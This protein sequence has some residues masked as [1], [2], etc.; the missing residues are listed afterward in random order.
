MGLFNIEGE[1]IQ[2]LSA[3]DLT[4]LLKKL[5]YMEADA[6]NIARSAQ[7]VPLDICVSDDGEDGRI[8]WEG[9]VDKTEYVPNRFTLFQSRAMPMFPAD[10][11]KELFV[12]KT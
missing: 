6:H 3:I 1:D 12:N 2:R 5:L 9:G 7:Y 11:K 4:R 8:K 10:C